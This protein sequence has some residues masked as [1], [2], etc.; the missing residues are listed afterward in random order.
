MKRS[1]ES[2][3]SISSTGTFSEEEITPNAAAE[4][5]YNHTE[6]TGTRKQ[7]KTFFKTDLHWWMAALLVLLVLF[8]MLLAIS[9]SVVKMHRTRAKKAAQEEHTVLLV[10]AETVDAKYGSNRVI[11]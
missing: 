10:E 5:S 8:A 4:T 9:K 6:M 2:L 7:V 11:E 1:L 3:T